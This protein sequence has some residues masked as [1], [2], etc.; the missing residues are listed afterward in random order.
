MIEDFDEGTEP[1]LVAHVLVRDALLDRIDENGMSGSE[2]AAAAAVVRQVAVA[3]HSSHASVGASCRT[4]RDP[5]PFGWQRP[6]VR[7]FFM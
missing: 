3:N 5:A 6:G 1:A 7:S 2:I 4:A